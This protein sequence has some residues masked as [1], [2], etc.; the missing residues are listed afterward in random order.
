MQGLLSNWAPRIRLWNDI[1]AWDILDRCGC[2]G[3]H[4]LLAMLLVIVIWVVVLM[5]M[6]WVF[7]IGGRWT[8]LLTWRGIGALHGEGWY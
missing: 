7:H 1:P 5:M 2:G 3:D 6:P 4:P 8:P